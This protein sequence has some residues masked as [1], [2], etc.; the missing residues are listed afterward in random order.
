MSEKL[1]KALAGKG[2]GSRR[3]LEGL[4]RA[5][6]VRVGQR[7]AGVGERIDNLD[8]VR[9]DGRAVRD[10]GPVETRVLVYHKPV[11]EIC[12]RRDP[13]GRP[14]VFERLPRMRGA[15]WVSVGRLDV[16]T[17][18]LLLFTNDGDL[19]NQLAHP[20]QGLLREYAVR[21]LG[22]V[23]PA[24]LQRLRAGVAL[25]DGMA[26]FEAIEDAGGTGANH[27][28]HVRIR[29]GRHREV[30]RL[31]QAVGLT[32]SRLIR[33]GYGP[34]KLDRKLR[35]GQ[36]RELGPGEI[37]ALQRSAG[38]EVTRPPRREA[39]RG[40]SRPSLKHSSRT[41]APSTGGRPTR[42]SKSSS[43]PSSR[44]TRRGATSNRRS[45]G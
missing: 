7:V 27:W 36:V 4:I 18:G 6:R 11:G 22:A 42:R 44:K 35:A 20:G 29:E 32:V 9:I 43:A 38:M 39:G 16:N 40:A 26:A 30:R 19:A 23:T 21:V 13:A 17:S 33:I 24:I 31:W 34:L 28:Y 12:T 10:S 41:T 45:R 5:G 3:Q 37:G 2:A 15:R 25:S 8:E 14:T 1:H